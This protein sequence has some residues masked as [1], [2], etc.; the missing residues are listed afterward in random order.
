MV[1]TQVQ[2]RHTYR[3]NVTILAELSIYQRGLVDLSKSTCRFITLRFFERV[4]IRCSL[5]DSIDLLR[6]AQV[7]RLQIVDLDLVTFDVLS[8]R[9][10][11]LELTL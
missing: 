6:Q 5:T 4:L 8:L 2:P 1:G 3:E 9:L 7:A 10:L 11:N